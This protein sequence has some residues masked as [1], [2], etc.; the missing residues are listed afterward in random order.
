MCCREDEKTETHNHVDKRDHM[1]QL[2]FRAFE[3]HHFLSET[4]GFIQSYSMRRLTNQKDILNAFT[5]LDRILSAKF[6]SDLFYGILTSH[7]DFALLWHP[8][9]RMV[10]REGFPSW[11][12]TGW[13]CP[14]SYA[15]RMGVLTQPGEYESWFI[16]DTWIKWFYVDSGG[17]LKRIR[18]VGDDLP[19]ISR[20]EM[21]A[22]R[23][24][25]EG[26][27]GG[28]LVR[29]LPWKEVRGLAQPLAPSD[30]GSTSANQAIANEEFPESWEG[31]SL[32]DS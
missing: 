14:V 28:N 27:A 29:K 5:A 13:E 12:W 25:A 16:T 17:E 4:V 6:K 31:K 7:F 15:T 3:G 24:L 22:R 11:S 19:P 2:L 18:H 20:R 21:H 32:D 26:M 10:R 9:G 30:E 1:Q 23:K 8:C